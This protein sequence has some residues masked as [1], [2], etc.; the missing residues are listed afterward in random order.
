MRKFIVVILIVIALVLG[1][2]IYLSSTT[3][4]STRGVH[5]PLTASQRALVAHM[6]ES[7]ESF[8]LIPS[9]AGLIAKLRANAVTQE[10]LEEWE[11]RQAMPPMWAIGAADLVVWKEGSRT[12]YAVQLDSLRAMLVRLYLMLGSDIDARWNGSTL[13]INAGDVNVAP[14]QAAELDSIL[15]MASSLPR[16]DVLAVQRATSRGAFPPIGR[17]AITAI[18]L[19]ADTIVLTSR[20]ARTSDAIA[21]PLSVQFPRGAM[22]ASAFVSPPRVIAELNRLFGREI[23][24]L[25]ADG[26]AIAIYDVD[27]HKLLPRPNGVVIM[28]A[29]EERR[30]ALASFQKTLSPVEAIGV[31]SYVAE[32]GNQLLLAFDRASNDAYIKDAFEPARTWPSAEWAVRIDP[33]RLVP[34]LEKLGDNVGFRIAAPKL[35]RSAR[36]LSRWIHY[37]RQARSIEAAATADG[38][39]SSLE[40]RISS[41]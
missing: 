7:A 23:S 9:A 18:S 21:G 36:D 11:K 15:A 30:A 31:D 40:V 25:L 2:A 13:L 3:P 1:L 5:V 37:L 22:I 10:P 8:A 24:T 27:T 32:S 41:K 14:T 6:P 26:G 33:Q 12:A 20:A 4:S 16:A 39:F 35:Y 34:V 19:D 17:P 28:P 29:T 38:Q